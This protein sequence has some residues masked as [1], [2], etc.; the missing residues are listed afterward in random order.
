M[1]EHSHARSCIN[2]TSAGAVPTPSATSRHQRSSSTKPVVTA[3]ATCSQL[4]STPELSTV[5]PFNPAQLPDGWI[6]EFDPNNNHPFWVDTKADPPRSTWVHPYEDEQFLREHPDIRDKI[7]ALRAKGAGIDDRPPPYS[8]RRH[9]FSG[10]SS[11]HLSAGPS[12]ANAADRNA[13]SHPPTP[14][15]G[16]AAKHRGFFG[17]MKDKAIGTKEEREAARKEEQRMMEQM[18]QRRRQQRAA[19]QPTYGAPVGSP[20]PGRYT[21][22][23]GG[24]GFGSSGLG[25]GG[26]GYGGLGYG[27][28]GGGSY[29]GYGRSSYGGLGGGGGFGGGGIGLP[30]LGGLAGGLLLGDVLDG[31]FGGGGFGGGGFGGGGFGGG[32]F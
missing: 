18:A 31:G 8:P 15:P 22:R 14:T 13:T 1:A 4:S 12:G 29:G 2:M 25:Y 16:S 32:F 27:G 19:Y 17:K 10:V 11:N 9:S 26:R 28:L 5:M 30:L 20:G 3:S 6:Q 23:Y 24:S 7:A 21:S